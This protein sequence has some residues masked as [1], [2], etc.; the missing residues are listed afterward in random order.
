MRSA[1]IRQL[2]GTHLKRWTLRSMI[3]TDFLRRGLPWTFLLLRERTGTQALN[4]GWRHRLSALA[5]LA[6]A[7]SVPARRVGVAFWSAA[8]FVTLNR[9]FYALLFRRRGAR[10]ASVGVA[11]HALHHVVGIAAATTALATHA[12]RRLLRR[13]RPTF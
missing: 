9:S 11:L 3:R 2:L 6:F 5:C 12:G 7:A 1:S 10:L 8:A 13:E 4:L